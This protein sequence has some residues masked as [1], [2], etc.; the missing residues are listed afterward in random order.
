MRFMPRL[1]VRA[2][3]LALLLA[4]ATRGAL[5]QDPAP[6]DSSQL[7]TLPDPD[8]IVA[9]A[10]RRRREVLA[11][12]GNVRYDAYVKLVARDL[13]T[14]RDPA[15]TVLF[16]SETHSSAYSEPHGHYQETIEAQRESRDFGGPRGLVAVDQI[17]NVGRASVVLGGFGGAERGGA[18]GRRAGRGGASRRYVV[19]LP[20]G[21]RAF[22]R[23]DFRLL[24][25][26]AV[27]GRRA[28]RLAVIPRSGTTPLF[29]GTMDVADSTYDLL[30]V[31][32]GLNDAVRFGAVRGLRYRET[33][34]DAGNGQWLPAEIRL[35]GEVRPRIT[36]NRL[37]REVAGIPVPGLPQTLAFEQVAELSG[38]RFH[39]ADR[40][41]GLG[42]YRVVVQDGADYADSAT[43]SAP[44]AP[45]LTDAER[46]A[47][48]RADSAERHPPALVR[49][50]R[51]I[52]AVGQLAANP[53][54][55]HFNR[56]DGYYLGLAPTWRV[57]PGLI[58]D[59]KLGYALGSEVWQYRFGGQVRLSEEGRMFLGA[60]YGDETVSRP[61]LIS[62]RY[63]PTFRALFARVDP[64][65]YYRERG[66]NVSLRTKL[67]DLTQLELRYEDARQS[68]L[69]T[70]PGYSFHSARYPARGNPPVADGHLRA[71]SAALTWDSRQMVRSRAGDYRLSPMS[72]TRITG[73]V[74][75]AEPALLADDFSYRRYMLEIERAQPLPGWGTTTISAVG[76]I[77]TGP[78][79]P[80]RYFTVDFGM[81]VL[82]VEGSGFRTLSRTNYYGNEAA[83]VTVR[84]DFD[85]MLFRRSGLPLIRDLPF[86]LSVQGGLF[87]TEFVNHVAGPADTMLVTAPRPY[88]EIGFSLGNLTP[89]L[90]PFNLSA[91]FAW[92]LSSYA[93]RRFRFGIGLSGP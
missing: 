45:P 59:T 3:L 54:Y 46:Q 12:I 55:F 58:L 33:L 8:S 24:D 2:P 42:E 70:L 18:F 57:L 86:T 69:D 14:T 49:I 11:A 29:V 48:A 63:N 78:V 67:L 25:T 9:R 82:A 62:S 51:G 36:A 56:V 34:A 43:W 77:A 85:R 10:I 27:G 30:A 53:G 87:W 92:Q 41:A 23:Y 80:Q 44:G 52:G 90:S 64:L 75:V 15:R 39:V 19:P 32:L 68:S 91:S 38:F 7:A 73:S 72:W 93:T 61:T 21:P 60:S 26:L 6:V 81:D 37:P 13:S 35:T 4:A 22:D 89:F 74:E 66:L 76:G 50:G 28:Y 88:S 16:L 83:V 31:D 1:H 20:L 79:P 65:D 71:I 5:A 17:V 47:W 84:H 40:P